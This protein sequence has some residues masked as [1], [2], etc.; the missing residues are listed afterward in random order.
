MSEHCL[1]PV[2]V[3]FHS[4]IREAVASCL[5]LRKEMIRIFTL[6]EIGVIR[7][8]ITAEQKLINKEGKL[9]RSKYGIRKRPEGF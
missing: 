7:K 1:N 2:V 8:Y 5:I 4:R 9:K 3:T 6:R